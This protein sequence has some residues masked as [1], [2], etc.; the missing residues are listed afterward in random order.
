MTS[1]GVG[2]VGTGYAAK[3]RAETFHGDGRSHLAA[4][5]GRNLEKTQEIAAPYGAIALT[6]WRT[7]VTHPQVDLVVIATINRDHGAIA[8]AALEANKHVVLEYPLAL[9]VAEAEPLLALAASKQRLLHVEHIE[10]LSGIHGAIAQSL[11]EI[12]TPFY[13]RYTDL[14]AKRPAPD[15]WSYHNDLFGFPFVGAL[16]RIHRLTN[17][18]GTVA[19][20]TCESRF[21]GDGLPGQAFTTC[22]ASAQLKFT[23]GLIA[24]V[25]YGKGE[26]LWSDER[27]LLIHGERGAIQIQGEVGKLILADEE[28]SLDLGS[29]RGL[30]AKDTAM[31]LDTLTTGKPLYVTLQESLY[32]L[33]VAE[34]TRRAAETGHAVSVD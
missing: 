21:W 26:A 14:T 17:L 5:A 29:R 11:P 33:R 2:V 23:N 7:L 10:L 13:V 4:I 32:A 19:H 27:V 15:R 31:V 3:V 6:D 1:I 28:R 18:F 20:V 24:D 9:T 34:A 8:R 12:G 16:S 22:I 25:V 30:F